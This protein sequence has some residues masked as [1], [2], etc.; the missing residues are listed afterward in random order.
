MARPTSVNEAIHQIDRADEDTEAGRRQLREAIEFLEDLERR[1]ELDADTQQVLDDV[2][3]QVSDN[4]VRD[5]LGDMLTPDLSPLVERPVEQLRWLWEKN[6]EAGSAIID[7]AREGARRVAEGDPSP[8]RWI[9]RRA[10]ERAWPHMTD[11]ERKEAED[12]GLAPDTEPLPRQGPQRPDLSPLQEQLLERSGGQGIGQEEVPSDLDELM[13]EGEQE[14]PFVGV[15]QDHMA[16]VDETNRQDYPAGT[17]ERE[18]PTGP[19]GYRQPRYRQSDIEGPFGWSTARIAQLQDRLVDAGL[20]TGEFRRGWYDPA[21][22]EAYAQA[23]GLANQRSA[24][25]T[26]ALDQ[27]TQQQAAAREQQVEQ[28]LQ[29]FQPQ[30]DLPPDPNQLRRR[31]RETLIASG[32]PAHRI[33]EDEVARMVDV[34]SGE[35]ARQREVETEMQRRQFEA[36]TRSQL[37]EDATADLSDLEGVDPLSSFDEWF[38]GEYGDEVEGRQQREEQQQRVGTFSQAMRSG[39][40]QVRQGGA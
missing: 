12:R 8:G 19:A 37:G 15:P 23:L 27:L 26:D 35:Y 9:V 20:L 13:G 10:T 7:V 40:Q 3:T 24:K 2:R 1:G 21:T 33:D 29:S 17:P 11:E 4:P 14:D 18:R 34:L 32:R 6:A 28:Q 22:G 25:V 38:Q 31:A 5:A 39:V 30:V 36:D 16:F